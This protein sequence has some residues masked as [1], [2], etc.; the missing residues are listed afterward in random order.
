MNVSKKIITIYSLIIFIVL[1]IFSI[2]FYK[3]RIIFTDSANYLFFS[4]Q[5]KN[6]SIA[7]N[8]FIA[9]LFEF[10][11]VL[12]IKQHASLKIVMLLYSIGYFIP[13]LVVITILTLFFKDYSK[14]LVVILLWIVGNNYD[15]FY[16]ASEFHKGIYVV[17][18]FWSSLENYLISKSK[19]LAVFIFL[20]LIVLLFSHPLIIFPIAFVIVYVYLKDKQQQINFPNYAYLLISVFLLIVFKLVFFKSDHENSK[21]EFLNGFISGFPYFNSNLVHTF[22][23]YLYS[24]Q[25][26]FICLIMLNVLGLI[27]TK[28]HSI[29][30]LFILF[31]FFYWLL[32]IA[33]YYTYTYDFYIEHLCKPL[34]F[35]T[36]SVFCME[37][38]QFIRTKQLI[39]LLIVIALYGLLKINH[40]AKFYTKHQQKIESILDIMK[41]HNISKGYMQA[42]NYKGM[43]NDE[44]WNSA[45][46]SLLLSSFKNTDTSRVVSIEYAFEKV[47]SDTYGDATCFY[48]G[49]KIGIDDLNTDYYHLSKDDYYVKVDSIIKFDEQ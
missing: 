29:L 23:G 35:F 4:T 38:M 40:T 20:L 48:N 31:F 11:Y 10:P 46:E 21:Y 45:V 32:I 14:A 47:G 28:N 43:L 9:Y 26:S 13:D 2:I 37:I 8:R 5:T 34:V 18:L 27:K 17:I 41:Q 16:T 24:H 39:A 49:Y 33:C 6:F 19:L 7:H 1:L 3:Q 30:I 42:Q 25:I 36:A 15:F 12:A 44:R 22:I